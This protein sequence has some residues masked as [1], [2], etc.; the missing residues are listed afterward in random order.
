MAH[1]DFQ[2]SYDNGIIASYR[3]NEN[4]KWINLVVYDPEGYEGRGRFYETDTVPVDQHVSIT[5][6][7][8]VPVKERMEQ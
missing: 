8:V 4:G 3:V 6:I 1:Y 2:E 7:Q 5:Q